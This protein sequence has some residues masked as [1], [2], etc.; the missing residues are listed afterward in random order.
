ML[1]SSADLRDV[2][3]VDALDSEV[4]LL[5]FLLGDGDTFRSIDSLVHFES[6]EVFNFDSL[7]K[8]SVTLP[9]SMT[10]TTIGKWE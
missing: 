10:F 1:N 6:Q 9:F 7:Y 8:E 4:V 5:L 3:E 2:L